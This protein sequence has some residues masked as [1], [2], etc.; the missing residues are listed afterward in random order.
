MTDNDNG[1]T[2]AELN[3]A[4]IA[5]ISQEALEVAKEYPT[6]GFGQELRKHFEWGNISEMA[7]HRRQ[8]GEDATPSQ[9]W[10]GGGFTTKLAFGGPVTAFGHADAQNARILYD[11][12]GDCIEKE[13]IHVND[14]VKADVEAGNILVYEQRKQEVTA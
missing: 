6:V 12:F 2:E 3:L 10:L 8:E 13:G 4:S 9:F 14:T 1:F 5:G 7:E 11:L